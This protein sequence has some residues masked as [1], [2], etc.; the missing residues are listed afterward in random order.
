MTKKPFNC[1]VFTDLDGTLLNADDYDFTPAEP[2][3]LQLKKLKIPVIP[4]TSKTAAEVIH[5]RRLMDLQDPFIIENGSAI[6]F[7]EHFPDNLIRQLPALGEYRFWVLGRSYQEILEML[8]RVKEE[9]QLPIQGFN[10]MDTSEIA[11][12]TGLNPDEAELSRLRLFS[13]PFICTDPQITAQPVLEFIRNYGFR[14]LK[15]NRFYHLLGDTDKGSA[16]RQTIELLSRNTNTTFHSIG[17]GDGPNDIELLLS[18]DEPV[19]V[20]RSAKVQFQLRQRSDVYYT[21]ETGASGWNEAINL[22]LLQ[23][24][25]S[26]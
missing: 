10:E 26:H 13:E 22:K 9:F 24:V 16:V 23:L 3:L 1:I 12:Y 7:P 19:I 15:G 8:N 14:L 20:R 18:V 2:A 25:D 5:L 6:V 4:C 11:S 17:L 21:Q